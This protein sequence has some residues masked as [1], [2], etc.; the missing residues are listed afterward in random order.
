MNSPKPLV[1]NPIGAPAMLSARL[2]RTAKTVSS[3]LEFANAARRNEP[4]GLKRV[5]LSKLPARLP[6]LEP[7]GRCADIFA[8]AMGAPMARAISKYIVAG[9][10][11]VLTAA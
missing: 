8:V 9:V 7:G 11:G 3:Q 6:H 1:A 2:A 10:I 4:C 5:G